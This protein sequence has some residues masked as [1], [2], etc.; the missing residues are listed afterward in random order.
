V[1][2]ADHTKFG[3]VAPHF[4]GR[5]DSVQT[6]VTDKKPQWLANA[7]PKIVVA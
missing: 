1:L 5:L 6:I 7:G 4:V 3:V 2:L